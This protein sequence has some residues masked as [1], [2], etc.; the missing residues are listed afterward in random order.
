MRF[1][2]N[3]INPKGA[4]FSPKEPRSSN[5]RRLVGLLSISCLLFFSSCGSSLSG[6]LQ[7]E[8]SCDTPEGVFDVK[9][10][11]GTFRIGRN[12]NTLTKGTWELN[13]KTLTAEGKGIGKLVAGP[14]SDAE[15]FS[16]TVDSSGRWAIG[17]SNEVTRS[18]G[19][20]DIEGYSVGGSG[21]IS[22]NKN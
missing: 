12:G 10:G 3:V 21:Q 22:C 11:D 18:G 19:Q 20:I 2:S 5:Q 14:I 15:Q 13:G 4:S 17:G 6:Q 16:I 1:R 9:I 7:G 8:W